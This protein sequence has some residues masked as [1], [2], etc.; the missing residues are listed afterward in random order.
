MVGGGSGGRGCGLDLLRLEICRGM[1]AVGE[2]NKAE[3]SYECGPKPRRGD[4][5]WESG[6]RYCREWQGLES[7]G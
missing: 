5:S 7:S 2:V 1:E 3:K 6:E 4:V